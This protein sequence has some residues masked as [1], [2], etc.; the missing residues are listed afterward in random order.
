M[1]REPFPET[2][3]LWPGLASRR[4]RETGGASPAPRNASDEFEGGEEIADF[5][6]GSFRSVGAMRAIVAD[7]GAQVVT[8]GARG[9][10]LGISGAHGV[11]PFEDGA[12]GFQDES[13]DFAGAHEVGE[14][15]KEGAF[16]VHGVEAASFGLGEAQGFDGDDL[17]ASFVNSGKDF[18]LLAATNGV[19]LDDGEGAFE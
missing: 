18:T 19:W 4:V 6:G 10:F 2:G 13:E 1:R 14:L 17:E 11:A 9:S 15:A 5:E 8:N 3:N 16:F 7:A 12:F